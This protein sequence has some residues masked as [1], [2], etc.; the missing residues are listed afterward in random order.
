MVTGYDM[1]MVCDMMVQLG[2]LSDFKHQVLQCGGLTVPM[3]EPIS[4]LGKKYLTSFD[5][6]EVIIKTAEPVST[7]VATERLVKI[8]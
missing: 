6:R 4:L 7:R 2:L 1:V 8:L 3:K 5:M